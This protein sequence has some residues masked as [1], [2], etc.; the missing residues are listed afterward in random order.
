MESV[1]PAQQ[2]AARCQYAFGLAAAGVDVVAAHGRQVEAWR[3]P[4]LP[5]LSSSKTPRHCRS[6]NASGVQWSGSDRN[7]ARRRRA[8]RRYA[9]NGYASLFH[10]TQFTVF[11]RRAASFQSSSLLPPR[12]ARYPW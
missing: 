2:I 1:G 12:C 8:G 10:L 3:K 9:D 6:K 5:Y 7:R 4:S 11:D